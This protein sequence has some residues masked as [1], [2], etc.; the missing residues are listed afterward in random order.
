MSAIRCRTCQVI[1]EWTGGRP[2]TC[3]NCDNRLVPA[4]FEIGVRFCLIATMLILFWYF[5]N[6]P[7]GY[8][9]PLDTLF[10]FS[11]CGFALEGIL[12]NIEF[13]WKVHL[14]TIHELLIPIVAVI[15]FRS[16]FPP[17]GAIFF[18]VPFIFMKIIASPLATILAL[19]RAA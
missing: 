15:L 2:G 19:E 18:L 16:E 13:F 1:N 12:F 6:L 3:I 17:G 8:G 5:G 14:P 11:A 9:M 10:A 7:S 4:I